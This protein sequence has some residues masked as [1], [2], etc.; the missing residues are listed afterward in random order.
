MKNA[1]IF[2][3]DGVIID[4]YEIFIDHFIEACK[5]QGF[6]QIAGEEEFLKLYEKNMYKSMFEM[7]MTKDQILKIV[8]YMK[9]QLIKN[10]YKIRLFP[11]IYETIKKLSQKNYLF[12]VTSNETTVV[13]KYLESKNIDFITEILG[14][15][16]EPSK[17]KKIK[18][19][20][21]KYV[22]DNYYYIGDT[23]GDIL[24]GKKAKVK[25]IAVSWGWFDK[26]RLEKTNPDFLIQKPKDLLKIIPNI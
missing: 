3:Y 13:K 4:S 2:D 7:G 25:T 16:I 18:S 14:S 8:L 23:S 5:I 22:A 20:K 17:I 19:I 9:K 24:E 21:T 11:N 1:I 6:P 26:K 15:D 10:Q 12:I